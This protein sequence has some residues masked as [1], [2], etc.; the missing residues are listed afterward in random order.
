MLNKLSKMKRNLFIIL[1]L[2]QLSVLSQNVK[3]ESIEPPF[4][5]A[6]M[7]NPNLQLM[8][9]GKDISN[10][11]PEIDYPGVGTGEVIRVENP[12]YLFVNLTLDKE[13]KPGTFEI[14]FKDN[15]EK[16]A[17]FEYRLLKREPGSAERKGFD[18]TDVVY[19]LMPDRFANGD[20]SN[21]DMP[22][23]LEKADRNN[24]D[25]RHGGDIK[26][27][28]GHLD[29]IS[30]LGVT[31]IWMNPLL[32]NNNPEYSYH[33]YAITDFYKTDPRF[34]T[35]EDYANL[36]KSSHEK[37]I[38]VIMD[39]IFNHA[40]IY[41]RLIKD[42][43]SEDWIHRFDKFT[44]SNF[45]ASTIPDPH[46]SE[47]D[48]K[49]F[50]TG[51]F[52]THM[53]DLNQKN[54]LLVNYLIQNSIWWIEF[55][56]IDGIRIDTQPYS[57]KEFITKWS[58]RVFEEYPSFNVVGEA[59]LQKESITAYFQKD[60]KNR[61]GYNS[62]IP[63]VTDFPMYYALS[64]AFT[65]RDGWTEGLA[66]IYYVLAQDFLYSAP[67]ENLIFCDNHDLDRIYSSLGEDFNI[68]KMAMATLLTMR[69]IPMIYYGT[70]ILMTGMA[71]DGHGYIRKDFPGGWPGDKTDA[72]TNEGR[73]KQQNE[74]YN[75]LQN[76]LKWRKNNAAVHF[77]ELKHF[78]PSED[79]YVYF[80]HSDDNCI[81]VA[82]NNSPNAVRALD[83]GRFGECLKKF[84]Y[85][86]NVITGE[87]VKYLDAF[88][89][90]P[91]SVLVL[92]FR[93]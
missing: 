17:G 44:R 28:A 41:N 30:D 25:G 49:I 81:M 69:G 32:E 66:R 52:D 90:P 79:T 2:I 88:S 62:G 72:F 80:R 53:A 21:D 3:I 82:L 63:S 12:N 83:T 68:W 1:T 89:L 36:V 87:T 74:A 76:L 73:T 46:A 47:Y 85:A 40:S 34:G 18:K 20:P 10:L 78:V 71:G 23:M 64:K 51:W 42:L 48:K 29:Y 59:W 91:K 26:G 38:K 92:E 77:G 8:I 33:G 54:E 67:E 65:E 43:P 93:K 61:D 19:L 15:G 16:A 37:G 22:G 39:M 58:S 86:V 7:V 56:G 70:E 50:L 84:N 14:E 13:V 24:P 11:E 27:I 55:S 6:G 57:E 45:R 31:A 9:Y 35:N 60:S 75:F 5:W 4:W